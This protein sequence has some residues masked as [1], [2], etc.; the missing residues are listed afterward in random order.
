MYELQLSTFRRSARTLGLLD[1]TRLGTVQLQAGGT[2]NMTLDLSALLPATLQGQ[3]WWQGKPLAGEHIEVS[4]SWVDNCSD[5][6]GET[7]AHRA[8]RVLLTDAEGGFTFPARGGLYCVR[9]LGIRADEQVFVAAGAEVHA[10]F[11][12][13]TRS[14]RLH[15]VG[16]D[17]APAVGVVLQLVGAG[18]EVCSLPATGSD[19]CT[20][21]D[22]GFGTYTVE[23]RSAAAPVRLATLIVGL[24]PLD[25][26]EVRLP[27]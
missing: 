16:A 23:T 9:W 26:V 1:R 15:V 10:E 25:V 21:A 4:E 11:H 3:V 17:G 24:Q 13:V 6:H 22:V 27:R 12:L 20:A 8:G 14:V 2:T 7:P 19:G 5:A 18:G